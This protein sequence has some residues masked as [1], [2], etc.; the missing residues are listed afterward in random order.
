M[1]GGGRG[2]AEHRRIDHRRA[3]VAVA[4]GTKDRKPRSCRGSEI[5][6]FFKVGN[7]TASAHRPKEA[8]SAS[9]FRMGIKQGRFV[10]PALGR[11]GGRSGYFGHIV[12][13]TARLDKG[14]EGGGASMPAIGRGISEGWASMAI[15]P[16]WSGGGGVWAVALGRGALCLAGHPRT[17]QLVF[18]TEGSGGRGRT[19][20][21]TSV[22]ARSRPEQVQQLSVQKPGLLDRFVGNS[23]HAWRD[24]E[25][26]RL[27]GLHVDDQLELGW[28]LHR[29]FGGLLA[30][31]NAISIDCRLPK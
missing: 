10:R 15:R 17:S 2:A 14:S 29:K 16:E 1:C 27:G 19:R 31:E 12:I 23:E 26:E 21:D 30:L 5:S 28:Q 11:H 6:P 4:A 8:K 18:A 13:P 20:H 3:A 22:S 7:T 9:V 25:A 24:C